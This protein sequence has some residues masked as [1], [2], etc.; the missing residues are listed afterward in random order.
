MA[1]ALA[2][3]PVPEGE[4]GPDML[5]RFLVEGE[6]LEMI[7]QR[8]LGGKTEIG[9]AAR[10]RGRNVNAFVFLDVDIDLGMRA[11]ETRQRLRQML[12]E[13]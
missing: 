9:G 3:P 8:V 5:I 13:P 7:G 12:G 10:N 11:Q 2:A 1:A 4:P 6:T